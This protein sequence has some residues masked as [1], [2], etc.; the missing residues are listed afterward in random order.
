MP[1]ETASDHEGP[2]NVAIRLS[3]TPRMTAATSVP[4]MLPM[5]PSTVM[6]NIRPM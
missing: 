5:P 2:K 3:A 4:P 1:N 6:A